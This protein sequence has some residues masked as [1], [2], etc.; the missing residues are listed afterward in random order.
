[1]E[2]R[3]R[4][5]AGDSAR[6]DL[7]SWYVHLRPVSSYRWMGIVAGPFLLLIEIVGLFLTLRSL[8]IPPRNLAGVCFGFA[9]LGLIAVAGSYLFLDRIAANRYVYVADG[10]VR[11]RGVHERSLGSTNCGT[12]SNS[13]LGLRW[14]G[15]FS[16]TRFNSWI[17]S[18][19]AVLEVLGPERSYRRRDL[20]MDRDP[21]K[22]RFLGRR[23]GALSWCSLCE[24]LELQEL[25]DVC[26][27]AGHPVATRMYCPARLVRS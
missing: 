19:A 26:D 20:A 12:E 17:C 3:D 16:G 9:F 23:F 5:I 1:M 22:P 27:H 2:P 4:I 24:A 15:Q 18:P 8:L 25:R 10:F 21:Q 7:G 14:E 11:Q 6:A 13:Q